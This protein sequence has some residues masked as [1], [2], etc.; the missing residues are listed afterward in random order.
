MSS[1]VLRMKVWPR[2]VSIHNKLLVFAFLDF[3]SLVFTVLPDIHVVASLL[4]VLGLAVVA[5]RFIAARPDRFY[6]LAP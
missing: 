6:G 5:A 1:P 3:L 2:L 4:P